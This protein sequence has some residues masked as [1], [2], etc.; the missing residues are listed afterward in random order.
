MKAKMF[1]IAAIFGMV[2]VVLLAAC[3]HGSPEARIGWIKEE[4]ADRLK[5]DPSHQQRLDQV[6]ASLLDRRRQMHKDREGLRKTIIEE[7]KKERIDRGVIEAAVAVKRTQMEEMVAFFIDSAI[8]LHETLTPA[9]REK[10]AAE[11]EKCHARAE[12]YG[13][14]R[15]Q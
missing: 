9:Q 14:H 4:I 2:T 1:W 10:L 12:K 8:G 3:Q 13:P 6:T 7:V 5:L 11:L 15:W